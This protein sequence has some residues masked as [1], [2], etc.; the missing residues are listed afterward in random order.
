[1][2]HWDHKF[3]WSRAEFRDWVSAVV[4]RY[5][6]YSELEFDGVGVTDTDHGPASQIVTFR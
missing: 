6:E 1:M 2:R 5:P 3:E 4:T